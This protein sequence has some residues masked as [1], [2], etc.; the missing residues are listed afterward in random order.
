M[1]KALEEKYGAEIPGRFMLKMDSHLPIAGSV[2]ARGG[3]YEVLKHDKDNGKIGWVMGPAF[4]FDHDARNAFSKL[5][6]NPLQ[7]I[8][9]PTAII[10]KGSF[11]YEN[12]HNKK[13]NEGNRRNA[14]SMLSRNYDGFKQIKRCFN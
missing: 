7:I 1:K 3:I 5:I 6:K 13:H 4:A 12:E 2:K 14:C 9:L 8:I 11:L 10:C